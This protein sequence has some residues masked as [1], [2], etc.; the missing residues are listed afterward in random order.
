MDESHNYMRLVF[1]MFDLKK[2]PF[3][4]PQENLN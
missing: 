4:T 2:R 1:P 3:Q